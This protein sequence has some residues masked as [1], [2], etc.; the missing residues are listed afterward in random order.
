MWI[1]QLQNGIT[2]IIAF[3]IPVA[4]ATVIKIYLE[5]IIVMR[6]LFDFLGH[7]FPAV[8]FLWLASNKKICSA[9]GE[10]A[11]GDSTYGFVFLAMIGI[12]FLAGA[13]TFAFEVFSGRLPK[14]TDKNDE[15]KKDDQS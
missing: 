1:E 15:K 12:M 4:L 2:I 14:P 10:T 3:A 7:I 6:K 8:I 11:L 9:I 5:K 13:I